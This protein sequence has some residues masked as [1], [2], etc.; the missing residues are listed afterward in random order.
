ME[1]PSST[2]PTDEDVTTPDDETPPAL[3]DALRLLRRRR[4]LTLAQVAAATD[5]S[6]SFLS[7]VEAGKSDITIGRLMRLVSFYDVSVTDLIPGARNH[8][9]VAVIRAGEG[10]ALSSPSEGIRDI[11]L[12]PDTKRSMLPLLAV[13]EVGGKNVETAQHDG[14]EFLYVVDGSLKV[15]I[16]GRE[17]VVLEPGDS[18]FFEATLPHSYENL[19]D[20]PARIVFVVTPPHL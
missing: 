12:A 18:M 13:F 10:R 15:M 19:A 14:E 5:I 3:G 9:P 20:C 7:L 11:V 1:S 2:R 8:Q 16:E 6:K 4:G 17:P